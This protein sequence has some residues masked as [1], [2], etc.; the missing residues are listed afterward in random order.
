MHHGS[1]HVWYLDSCESKIL[2]P[3]VI[4][5]PCPLLPP[6]QIDASLLKLSSS[7]IMQDDLGNPPYKGSLVFESECI[8]LFTLQ[9]NCSS[10]SLFCWLKELPSILGCSLYLALLGGS[11]APTTL[12]RSDNQPLLSI[13]LSSLWE[14]VLDVQP[15]DG[16]LLKTLWLLGWMWAGHVPFH[17]LL[18]ILSSLPWYEIG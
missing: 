7:L 5:M 16:W 18:C 15:C 8:D 9:L 3:W 17:S 10:L 2:G 6:W 14:D 13:S 4:V 12:T 1:Y 11:I